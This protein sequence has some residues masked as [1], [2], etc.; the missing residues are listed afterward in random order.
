[1]TGRWVHLVARNGVSP[2]NLFIIYGQSPG[3]DF[4]VDSASVQTVA[5]PGVAFPVTKAYLEADP[6]DY[7][8]RC[9]STIRFYGTISANGIGE[10]LFVFARSDGVQAVA[11]PL[12]FVASSSKPIQY[13][14]AVGNYYS[15]NKSVAGWVQA[16]VSS[17]NVFASNRAAFSVTCKND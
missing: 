4:F 1:V 13:A 10:V 17:P 7:V 9:P 2:A 15:A 12:D 5:G 16:R 6:V 11:K 14:W 8:G 3:A